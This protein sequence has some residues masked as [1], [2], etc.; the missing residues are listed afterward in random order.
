MK[1]GVISDTHITNTEG[2]IPKKILNEF[3]NVDMIIHAGDLITLRVLDE[4][5]SVCNNV[6]A[7][8]GNMDSHEVR[9]VLPEKEI[10]K[11]GKFRIGVM[12]GQGS[13]SKI[14]EFLGSIFKDSEVDIVIFG[15]SHESFNE[16]V[17][18][19]LFFNPGSAT[20]KIFSTYNSFGL[21]EINGTIKSKII[22][23]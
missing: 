20:D 3:K 2:E 15:H 9:Q 12:H 4:L 22:K 17:G 10:L 6:T 1:I 13:P 14:I 21:I 7:V 18:N 16:K 11:V 19:I 5:R 23:L 8:Y